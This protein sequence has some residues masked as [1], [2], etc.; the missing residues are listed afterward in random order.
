MPAEGG[1]T[2]A[3]FLADVFVVFL[4]VALIWLLIM[5]I[6]DLFRRQDIPGWGKAL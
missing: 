2:F 3:S 4:F 5:V 1:F 6:F